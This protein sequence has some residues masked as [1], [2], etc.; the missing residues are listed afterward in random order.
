MSTLVTAY[1]TTV[2]LA[3]LLS[4]AITILAVRKWEN[5]ESRALAALTTGIAL[6]TGGD[7]VS[8]FASSREW[9]IRWLQVHWLG[10]VIV[11]VA[12]FVF[13]LVYTGR[14]ERLS[15]GRVAGLY[16]LPAVTYLL[17]LSSPAHDLIWTAI[18]PTSASPV[19]Y[20]FTN[21]PAFY[22][23]ALYAYGLLAVASVLLGVFILRSNDL[24]RGQ[25]SLLMVAALAPWASNLGY[26]FGGRVLDVTS[27]GFAVTAVA[28]GVAL[29]RYRLTDVMPIART[30]V[31][32]HI[33]DGV[34]VL[35]REDRLVDVNRR[36]APYIRTERGD[37]PLGRRASEV[38]PDPMVDRLTQHADR[39][40]PDE[41]S[42]EPSVATTGLTITRDGSQRYLTVETT[43]LSNARRRIGRLVII[44]DVTEE[45]RY[46]R[47]LER[48][49]DRLDRFASLVS[50]DL[51]NPLNVADGYVSILDERC[52]DPA[53]EEITVSLDR[54]EQIID[55]V[56]TLTRHGTVLTDRERVE[57]AT[58]VRSAWN[59]VDTADATLDV[60]TG[61]H[62][63]S[64]DPSRLVQ[65]FENLFRNAVEHGSTSPHSHVREETVEHGGADVTVTVGTITGDDRDDS[66]DG[67][68]VADDGPGIPAADREKILESG[69]STSQDG[70][71]LGLDIVTQILDAHGWSLSVDESDSGGA[72]FEIRYAADRD[73]ETDPAAEPCEL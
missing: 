54:M 22:V 34:I 10:V 45:R 49:N 15:R 70:T 67:F 43:P 44:R 31:V 24:Y 6:W 3:V 40:E 46:E 13:I 60:E 17:V 71:G 23:Y 33:N 66:V 62:A 48:Q 4:V 55:D 53:L 7:F 52:D 1:M 69:Y 56:L 47:E 28:L 16:A 58:V 14:G 37:S 42:P 73:G 20:A 30:T 38:L 41:S 26:V 11:P 35:D 39:S 59:G 8:M 63:V 29:Y 72:R 18:E 9:T 21:G 12:V 36:A 25:A 2:F 19:G 65:A 27:I 61:D 57:L 68:Y 5:P 51:R 32:E 64:T 50:H